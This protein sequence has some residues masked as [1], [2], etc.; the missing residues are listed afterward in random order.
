MQG[1]LNSVMG[2]AR[3]SH[4]PLENMAWWLE[5]PAVT[6]CWA[7]LAEG[8]DESL[9]KAER[10]LQELLQLNQDNHNTCHMIHIMPLLA[11]AYKKQDR[12][13]E[14]LPVLE[15]TDKLAKPGGFIRPFVELGLQWPTC[16]SG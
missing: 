16:S 1:D 14:A 7:L 4:P 12:I 3:E 9:K 11:L 13:D 6:H 10:K 15:R 8:S 2:W 5:I